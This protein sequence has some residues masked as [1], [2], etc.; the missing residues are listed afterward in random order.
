MPRRPPI[1]TET[2]RA[3]AT[4]IEFCRVFAENMDKLHLLSFLLTADLAKA[5]E[6]FVSGLED[7]VEG[8]YV[9]RDWAQSW[10]RRTIIQNAIRMLAPRKD[11]STVAD[12]PSDVVSCSSGQTQDADYAISR[13]LRL[14]HFERFIFVMSVLEKYSDQ[15]CSVLLG[16]SRQNVGE[17][18]MRAL[19]HLAEPNTLRTVAPSGCGS[20]DFEE[21]QTPE[22]QLEPQF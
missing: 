17:T 1:S 6:C 18:R 9:F 4:H 3:Y 7:C 21:A 22:V 15:D 20:S 10:A 12:A 14:E 19:L 2:S 11:P 13:I 5:E 16:C 8:T